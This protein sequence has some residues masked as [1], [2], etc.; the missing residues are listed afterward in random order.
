[1]E[2][3][4]SPYEPPEHNHQVNKV[5]AKSTNRQRYLLVHGLQVLFC[6]GACLSGLVGLDNELVDNLAEFSVV[7]NGV[8]LLF[9]V[10]WICVDFRRRYCVVWI[11]DLLVTCILYKFLYVFVQ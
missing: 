11:L 2:I 1:M 8:M 6:I 9:G 5:A 10:F 7:S 3:E 4:S